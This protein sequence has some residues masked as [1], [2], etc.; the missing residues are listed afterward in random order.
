M[1][2]AQLLAL[3]LAGPALAPH[4]EEDSPRGEVVAEISGEEPG[5]GTVAPKPEPPEDEADPDPPV[6]SLPRPTPSGHSGLV[7]TM[8]ADAGG[9]MGWSLGFT[10]TLLVKKGF[11]Y[12]KDV[13]DRHVHYI[14]TLH[15]SFAPLR[16]LE[17][18]LAV[19]FRVDST[20]LSFQDPSVYRRLGNSLFGV[21]GVLP[22]SDLYSIALAV[23]PRLYVEVDGLSFDWDATSVSLLLAQTLDLSVRSPVPLRIHL[24]LGWD[25]NNTAK[26]V[27]ERE[28]EMTVEA[29][30]P[31]YVMRFERFV[32][33]VSRT[34]FL[35]ATLALEA[36]TS[37]A[38]PFIEWSYRIP[39]ARHQF[40]CLEMDSEAFPDDDSCLSE[41][42]AGAFHMDL[43][44]GLRI[45][46]PSLPGLGILIAVDVGLTG[47]GV[48]VREL[49]A[50]PPYRL[51]L[52]VSWSGQVDPAKL[53]RQ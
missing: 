8:D 32:L 18:F 9:P 29:G 53:K 21:K 5:N 28:T 26:L 24:N 46:P 42:K 52:G 15:G 25:F 44:L 1:L 19:G 30:S 16:F 27:E 36:S 7:R 13:E 6:K 35:L 22:V 45:S 38:S 12:E 33:D 34:D 49:P 14:G 43:A 2:A 31:R 51:V 47:V 11:L 48:N 41:K 17:I 3:V 23:T 10:S 40:R 39:V 37:W 20:D 50:H 4:E